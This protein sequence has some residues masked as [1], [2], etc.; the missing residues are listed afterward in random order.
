VKSDRLVAVLMALQHAGK[1]SATALAGRLEV[2][3][4]T[5]YR[6]VDALSAAGIPVYAERGSQGGIVLAD[7]YRD[8]LGRFD[9]DELRALFVSSEDALADIG[10]RAGHRS[11]LDKL[12]RAMPRRARETVGQTRGRVHVDSRRWIGV[13][14]PSVAL[15]ALR[16]AVWNDRC[17]MIAYTDRNGA[18]TRRTLDPLG[19]VTKAGIWYLVARDGE[20]IKTFRVQRIARVR[21]L[22]RRFTRPAGFDIAEY[23]KG[24]AA[25]VGSE[26]K[27]YVATFRMSRAALSNA[28]ILFKVASRRRIRGRAPATWIARI[29]FPAFAAAIG[30]ALEWSDEAVALD[31]PELCSALAERARKLT[32]RYPSVS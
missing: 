30:E 1:E 27:P 8:T 20:T 7:S 10:L 5:I 32:E 25:F 19:L 29:E 4:R 23:W 15:A 26:E 2:S 11:A 3:V 9:D 17:V 24:V 14:S 31:P 28:A 21:I 12:A 6:D 13:S 22:E 16:D 18:V